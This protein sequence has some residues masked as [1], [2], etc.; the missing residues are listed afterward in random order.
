MTTSGTESILHSF[1]GSPDGVEPVGDL[2]LLN[3]TF[4][5]TTV[6]GGSVCNG[7]GCGT[8]FQFTPQS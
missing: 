3:G 2:F 4:Y 6:Y 8:V 7:H 1:G 5:G